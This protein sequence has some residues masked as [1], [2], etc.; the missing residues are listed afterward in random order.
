MSYRTKIKLIY[1]TRESAFSFRYIL[2]I[3]ICIISGMVKQCAEM[4]QLWIV[5]IMLQTRPS[6][7]IQCREVTFIT[8]CFAT[9]KRKSSVYVYLEN[10]DLTLTL[11]LPLLDHMFTMLHAAY[12]Q[13]SMYTLCTRHIC[14]CWELLTESKRFY[15]I[16]QLF[17]IFLFPR[18][19]CNKRS[20]TQWCNGFLMLLYIFNYRR[21]PSPLQWKMSRSVLCASSCRLYELL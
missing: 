3:Q 15:I 6:C 7:G 19:T 8:Q 16:I 11:T 4:Q 2:V 13:Y 17:I 21:N 9:C 20:L 14:T 1:I 10:C 5:C 12:T 18:E